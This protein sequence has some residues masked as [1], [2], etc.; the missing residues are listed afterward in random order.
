M[1]QGQ[2]FVAVHFSKV[3][4]TAS[5]S[6]LFRQYQI[7]K[8]FR[9]TGTNRYVKVNSG[10]PI[11]VRAGGSVQLRVR[12]TPFKNR[13]P[14][15][16]FDFT[17]R[18]PRGR[19]GSSGTFE[20]DGGASASSDN[21]FCLFDP[22]ACGGLG[23]AKNFSQILQALGRQPRND[24]L[25]ATMTIGPAPRKPGSRPAVTMAQVRTA[26]EI[27]TGMLVIPVIVTR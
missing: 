4:I 12:L 22:N 19:A 17:Y 24:Q 21:T 14:L 5:A 15:R 10:T 13:G 11:R 9:K 23:G 27:V 1:I 3:T 7:G 6:E 20:V 26:T 16:N 2:P 18:I 8:V 25:I